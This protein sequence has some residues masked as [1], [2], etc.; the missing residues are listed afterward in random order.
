MND[1]NFKCKDC[2]FFEP[3]D[4]YND[5]ITGQC[6]LAKVSITEDENCYSIGELNGEIH[7]VDMNEIKKI[8]EI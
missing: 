2:L 1:D 8:I 4:M 7:F 3:N 5:D 6:S